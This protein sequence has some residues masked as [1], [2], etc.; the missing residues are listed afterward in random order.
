MKYLKMIKTIPYKDP[1]KVTSPVGVLI[2]KFKQEELYDGMIVCSIQNDLTVY[3]LTNVRNNSYIPIWT[4][5]FS[6]DGK[7]AQCLK[8]EREVGKYIGVV[9]WCE[10]EISRLLDVRCRRED[11]LNSIGI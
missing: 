11:I 3:E 4:I 1:S 10:T 2:R 5:S 9:I 8:I 6:K 7:E